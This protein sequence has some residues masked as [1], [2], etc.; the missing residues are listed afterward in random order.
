MTF[1]SFAPNFEDILLWRAL[2]DEAPGLYVDV[3]AAD[4]DIGSITRAFHERGWR[5]L[6]VTAVESAVRRLQAQRLGDICVLAS[7]GPVTGETVVYVLDGALRATTSPETLDAWRD[8]GRPLHRHVLPM[9]TLATLLNEHAQGDIHFL[10]IDAEGD[11]LAVLSGAEFSRK[12]PWIIIVRAVSPVTGF[13]SHTP[14][15]AILRRFDY[16][17][18]WFDGLSRFYVARERLEK[19]ARHFAAPIN[20]SDD[21]LRAADT[22]VAVRVA[23]AEQKLEMLEQ[24]AEEAEARLREETREVFSQRGLNAQRA[25]YINSLEAALTAERHRAAHAEAWVNLLRSS[26]SWRVTAPLR[27]LVSILTKRPTSTASEMPENVAGAAVIPPPANAYDVDLVFRPTIAAA[28]KIVQRV[29]QYHPGSAQADAVTNSMLLIQRLLRGAGF[30]SE[31]YCDQLDPEIGNLLRPASELPRHDEYVLIVHFSLGFGTFDTI[32]NLAARKILMYHNITPPDLLAQSPVLQGFA[33]LGLEQLPRF[34]PLVAAALTVSEFNALDLRRYGFPVVRN[35]QLLFDIDTILATASQPVS[36]RRDEVFTIIFV[37]RLVE[38]KAQDDLVAAFAVFRKLWAKPCRLMLVGRVTSSED[39]F[40]IALHRMID[41]L[42]LMHDVHL[43]GLVGD[44]QLRESYRH[45]DLYVSLSHHEGFGVPLIEAMAHGVPVLAW[46]CGAVPYTL[47]ESGELLADRSPDAVAGRILELALDPARRQAISL[48]QMRSLDRFR[49]SHHVPVLLEALALAGAVA[50]ADPALRNTLNDRMNFTIVGHVN[51]SYSL[52][53]VNRSLVR[54]VEAVRPGRVRMVA[55]EGEVTTDLRAVPAS[56]VD[57]IA[58]LMARQRWETGPEVVISQHYPIYV[59]TDGGDLLM[60]LFF[61]EE[62]IIPLSTVRTINMHF[63]AVLAPSSFVSKTLVDSGV[64]VPVSLIGQ[65]PDLSAFR[66]L[67]EERRQRVR[68]AGPMRL[69]HISSCY[70]RK[71]VDVLLAAYARAF[72]RDDPVRLVIKGYP[73]PHNNVAEQV[74]AW[75]SANLDGPEIEFINGDLENSALLDLYRQADVM[76]LPTRGEGFN[77]PAAEAMAAR[78]PLIVTGFGGQ[79]DFCDP[80][81]AR[82][83][84]WHYAPSQ[85]H[86][87]TSMS[88]WAEPSEDDLVAALREAFDMYMTSPDPASLWPTRVRA[89]AARIDELMSNNRLVG[90]LARSA[91]DVIATK[92]M[93]PA[94]MVWITTWDVRCG[95]AEYARHLLDA[96][97]KDGGTGEVV[98]LADSRTALKPDAEPRRQI[99]WQIGGE[100]NL[101]QTALIIAQEDPDVVVIQHQPGFMPWSE[102]AG[103]LRLRHLARRVVTVTLHNTSDLE[104]I[105]SANRRDIVAALMLATRVIVHSITDIERL[106]GMGLQSNVVVMPHGF[107]IL[108][109]QSTLPRDLSPNNAPVIGC[110]GFF[111][112]GKGI[113]ELI[114]AVALLRKI[115]PG[116][117]L[118]LVNARY[119]TPESDAEIKF[120]QEI[121]AD[122]GLFSAIEWHTDFL[123]IEQ[124]WALLAGCDVVVLPYQ[125]SGEASSAA[126]RSAL[127]TCVPV[128]VTP[129]PVFDDAEPAVFRLS[130]SDPAA[131]AEGVRLVLEKHDIRSALSARATTFM[132]DNAWPL[133]AERMQGMLLGLR[134][135][136]GCS[137]CADGQT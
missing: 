107:P 80:S 124:S 135:K 50:P 53:A 48:R 47:G 29:H 76:V 94:R 24:R 28:G 57:T 111:V 33:Q 3:G 136:V 62:S 90:A 59:P 79:Q 116:L 77:L 60:A 97:P 70:P 134:Y 96:W 30:E 19:L 14:W 45:A 98:I 55:V 100:T 64:R 2:R 63:R 34:K 43:T 88:I 122:V 89:A 113:R 27:K 108:P 129:L 46:P 26:S 10:R 112:P 56:E 99:G 11:E 41:E 15:E 42:D 84:S 23:R 44:N 13:P 81:T 25:I 37:G 17:F 82:L 128:A 91:A 101:L 131:I 109:A 4:P 39:T 86:L 114:T 83:L 130:G 38:S 92:P 78:L 52:A 61:W 31:I 18:T 93:Q 8:L 36:P 106:K 119:G 133:V 102:L 71:G 32:A 123:P 68:T 75:Q 95:V 20:I 105:G 87:A 103:L 54:A 49:L 85:S 1:V 137:P 72:R 110:F 126:L 6:N 5:G 35:C 51:G 67:G 58:A 118:R 16:D 127:A 121:A 66:R 120:C 65:S 22:D 40:M 69:L 74:A 73:N 117:R 104:L 9:H 132:Q 125:S 21:F 115:W 12:R 7:L